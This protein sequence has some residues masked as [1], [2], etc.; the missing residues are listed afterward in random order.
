[1]KIDIT[2]EHTQMDF[3]LVKIDVTNEHTNMKLDVRSERIKMDL[4][5]DLKQSKVILLF[6]GDPMP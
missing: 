3:R 6:N 5:L 2:S 1:M 4:G